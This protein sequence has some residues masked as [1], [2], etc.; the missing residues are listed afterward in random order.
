MEGILTTVLVLWTVTASVAK[1]L[2]MSIVV[3]TDQLG[4]KYTS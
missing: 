1:D 4:P 2:V 3:P